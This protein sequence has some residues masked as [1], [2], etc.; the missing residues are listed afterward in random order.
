MELKKLTANPDGLKVF[1]ADHDGL[2]DVLIFV[3]YDQPIMVRQSQ[4]GKFEIVDSP[5]SQAS[6]IK[7]AKASSTA[8]AEKLT[9]KKA[10]TCSLHSRI[11]PEACE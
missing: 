2:P 3:S 10:T 9:A 8:V 1:D 7:E 5:N 11:S 6:L 4:K